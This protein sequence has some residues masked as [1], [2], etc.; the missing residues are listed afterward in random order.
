M[1]REV[2]I[3][4]SSWADEGFVREWYPPGLPAKRRLAHY[5]QYFRAVEVNSTFYNVPSR[6][7]VAR[8]AQVTPANFS[9]DVKLHRALSRHVAWRSSLP[10]HLQRIAECESS[11]RLRLTPRLQDALLDELLAAL[12]PLREAGKLSSL[13]LQLAP[14]FAPR[15]HRLD[16]LDSLIGRISP[17]RLAIEFRHR[18]WVEP[19]RLGDTLDYLRRRSVAFVCVDAPAGVHDTI[20]PSDLDAVTCGQLAYL[21]AHGRNTH[22]YLHGRTVAERFAYKYSDPELLQMIARAKRMAGA[23]DKGDTRVM[24]NNNRGSDAPEA[25]RRMLE[26]LGQ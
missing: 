8:W 22:G 12:E 25:A 16:E 3:G 19:A 2:V 4:T 17:L 14:S 5:A 1:A 7:M 6:K 13:L 23:L 9:F 15:T 10:E 24:L 18:G 20:M 26:L 21:R 11:G